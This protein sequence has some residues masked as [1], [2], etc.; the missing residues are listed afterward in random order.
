MV[1]QLLTRTPYEAPKLALNPAVSDFYAFTVDD[2]RLEG[3][4]AHE[5]D[6][7][8]PVAV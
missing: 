1:E 3:Y 5:L 4:Q 7:P 8:I 2:V 6:G